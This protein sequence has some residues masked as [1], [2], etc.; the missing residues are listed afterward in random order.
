MGVRGKN[1]TEIK[2]HGFDSHKEAAKQGESDLEVK[3]TV[4]IIP[5]LVRLGTQFEYHQ[6]DYGQLFLPDF[7]QGLKIP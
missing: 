6:Y 2:D 7:Y 5:T 4:E 1:C 3:G